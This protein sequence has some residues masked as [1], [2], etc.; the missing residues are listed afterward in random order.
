[1]KG[2]LYARLMIAASEAIQRIIP[3]VSARRSRKA[4]RYSPRGR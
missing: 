4:K 2:I 1:M 3:V